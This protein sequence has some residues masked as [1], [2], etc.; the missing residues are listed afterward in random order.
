MS[1]NSINK[2]GSRVSVERL[3]ESV[4]YNPKTGGFAWRVRPVEHFDS[5]AKAARWNGKYAGKAAFTSA[6]P[7]G[8]FRGMIDG[9]MLYAHRAARAIM[10]GA[11]PDGEVDHINRDKSDN[12]ASNLRIVTHAENRLNTVDC[13]RAAA[14]RAAKPERSM[15]MPGVRRCGTRWHVRAKH[16]RQEKHLGTFKCFAH[17]VAARLS[18]NGGV[19]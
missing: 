8:Y 7:R 4:T 18:F 2:I 17:A 3:A 9:Q 16:Q 14:I 10:D 15:R 11:W 1:L 6:D 12:R 13:D 5:E 19:L